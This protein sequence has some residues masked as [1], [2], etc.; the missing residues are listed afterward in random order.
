MQKSEA[1]RV[2]EHAPQAHRRAGPPVEGEVAVPRISNDRM[3]DGSQMAADLVG[4][5][6]LDVQL[7][8]RGLC[9]ARELAEVGDG[10]LQVHAADLLARERLLVLGKAHVDRPPVLLEPSL[11]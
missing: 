8:K 10:L 5:P 7:E 11:R 4:P 2:E 9:A 3:A 6:R 1:D